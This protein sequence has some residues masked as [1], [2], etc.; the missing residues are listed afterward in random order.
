MAWKYKHISDK[1]GFLASLEADD[2]G[3][4][5]KPQGL[6]LSDV[7]EWEERH[8]GE[9][10]KR[11]K[12][13][14]DKPPVAPQRAT[15]VQS[16]N[17]ELK[18]QMGSF[19]PV[20]LWKSHF[21]EKDFPAH[22][23]QKLLFEGAE[24]EGLYEDPK[25]GWAP[26][27]IEVSQVNN[28]GQQLETEAANTESGLDNETVE[29]A[30]K[31]CVANSG[32][33]MGTKKNQE[34]GE[35]GMILVPTAP[36]R[37]RPAEDDDDDDGDFLLRYASTPFAQGGSARPA[38]DDVE[39]SSGKPARKRAKAKAKD[40][41][42]PKKETVPKSTPQ[43][44]AST[45]VPKAMA[46]G[47]LAK[48]LSLTSQTVA[49]AEVTL[50]L[51]RNDATIITVKAEKCLALAK[52]LEKRID[53][54][55][56]PIYSEPEQEFWSPRNLLRQV[57]AFLQVHTE[58]A[59]VLKSYYAKPVTHDWAPN[60][61]ALAITDVEGIQS[62]AS[63]SSSSPDF[64]VP[65]VVRSQVVLRTSSMMVASITETYTP[66]SMEV[67]AL[68][69]TTAISQW[70]GGGDLLRVPADEANRF[71]MKYVAGCQ[72]D[73]QQS[74]QIQA[75]AEAAGVLFDVEIHA[76]AEG[77]SLMELV[78][79]KP[80][81]AFLAMASLLQEKGGMDE[82]GRELLAPIPVFVEPTNFPNNAVNDALDA[83]FSTTSPLQAAM[84]KPL[85]SKVRTLCWQLTIARTKDLVA[86]K[87]LERVRSQVAD[88]PTAD[89]W[90]RSCLDKENALSHVRSRSGLLRNLMSEF[91]SNMVKVSEYFGT[92][93]ENAALLAE[94]KGALQDLR[95][96][97]FSV[98]RDRFSRAFL[99]AVE[100]DLA[101]N[102]RE[103]NLGTAEAWASVLDMK[104]LCESDDEH[105]LMVKLGT[106]R[107]QWCG[108]FK[109]VL[110]ILDRAT[111]TGE[112]VGP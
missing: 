89:A 3:E 6:F 77:R 18:M 19:W 12:R 75:F 15:L 72:A 4:P 65:D 40:G 103:T 9:E 55:L 109:A 48:E 44:S 87:G 32:V 62:S 81:R 21:T 51:A 99:E 5:D 102:L 8:D 10:G 58:L 54:K 46:G 70:G 88:T 26:G 82:K 17:L 42:T 85:P 1:K 66:E 25:A 96:H 76:D 67:L 84:K 2:S 16:S 29:A 53:P 105:D 69:T 63:Q 23:V 59:N 35:E 49:E 43:K 52:K 33:K 38:A 112:E 47:R 94:V 110:P 61:L 22:R 39:T 28:S 80:M 24:L 98:V 78:Q 11:V 13:T 31:S 30:F 37:K 108:L 111:A 92:T 36:S 71:G 57:R 68:E 95:T 107:A 79:M 60:T 56:M 86:K 34:T 101:H 7:G 104:G 50:N 64:R 45:S 73:V 41:A 90:A 74:V 97:L 83:L 106:V 93:V 20:A 91:K 14:L 100:P 27:V